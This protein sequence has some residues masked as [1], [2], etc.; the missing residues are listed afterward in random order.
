MKLLI[1]SLFSCLVYLIFS[2]S[3]I[4]KEPSGIKFF[5]GTLQEA[6]AKSK[7]ENKI[8]FID[9]YT[10]W[11]GWCKVMDKKTFTDSTVGAFFNKHYIAYKLDMERGEGIPV[12]MSYRVN[13]FPSYLFFNPKGELIQKSFGYVKPALFLKD[14]EKSLK[15]TQLK[16]Y[17]TNVNNVKDLNFPQ[18]FIDAHKTSKERI[19]PKQDT[20]SNY[21]DKQENLFNE[22]NWAILCR[23]YAGEK[24]NDF[25]LENHIKYRAKYGDQEV[26]NELYSILYNKVVKA[27]KDSNTKLLNLQLQFVKDHFIEDPLWNYYSLKSYYYK[28]QKNWMELANILDSQII[29]F[30][31]KKIHATVNDLS[32]DFYKNTEDL[33]LLT[34]ATAWMKKVIEVNPEYMYLDTYAAL[35]YKT[36]QYEKAKQYAELAITQGKIEKHEVKSTVELLKKIKKNLR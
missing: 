30:G 27:A 3:A 16:G 19:W 20:I 12:R 26:E 11:C 29:E 18:F 8:L 5:K 35:L 10:E 9:A 14:C 22:V 25:L 23:M 13:G 15:A 34:R 36:K 32:W 17:S 4:A 33:K 6:I 1:K 7:A 2:Q 24:W 31:Y 21:L 28:S